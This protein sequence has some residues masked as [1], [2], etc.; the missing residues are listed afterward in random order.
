MS[1][2]FFGALALTMLV[3]ATSARAVQDPTIGKAAPAFELKD[4]KGELVTAES[5]KDKSAVVYVFLGTACPIANLYLPELNDLQTELGSKG[6]QV[7]GVNS[8]YGD[9]ADAIRTHA[10]EYQLTFPVLVDAERTLADGLGAKRTPEVFIA[11]AKGIVRYHGRIDD[12]YGYTYRRD[13]TTR[14]DLAEAVHEILAGKEVSLASTEPIGCLI[15]QPKASAKSSDITY[16]KDISRIVRT[17]CAFCHQEG[18]AAPFELDTYDQVVEWADT[19]KEVI[20]DGRMPPWHATAEYGHFSNDRRLTDTE[21]EVLLAWLDSDRAKGD[22]ADLPPPQKAHKTGWIIGEPDVVLKMPEKVKIQADGVVAYQYYRTPTNFKED[23]WVTAAEARPGNRKVVHHII[24]FFRDPNAKL[25]GEIFDGGGKA[26]GFLVGTAP[27]D[28]PLILPPGVA[29][30]IPAGAELIWQ[31][32]YTPTGKE[33]EDQSEVGLI[34]HKGPEPPKYNALTKGISQRWFKIPAGA[35]NHRVDSE[36]V[37]KKDAILLSFMPHMHLRGKAF[38]YEATYPDG[39]QEV[40]LDIPKYDFNW[41]STY[42]L[43]QPKN[44]PKGTKIHCIAHFDNS[45]NNKANPDPTKTVF[46]GDQ[47][48]EEMMIGWIDYMYVPD[49]EEEVAER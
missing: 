41:Q 37:F 27:G 13:N 34:F 18:A 10:E 32:H 20:D 24:L 42:R 40:L 25:D 19:I 17:K 5:L 26:G 1:S 7:I 49:G 22:D 12:R 6:L 8:N 30:R 31:M 23:M 36:F 3:A 4:A 46:W 21:K 15:S 43:A 2:K 11:D 39:T 38:H 28:M 14:A 16:S 29:R 44:M 45:T 47:T 9:D 33:E 35:D 48:W